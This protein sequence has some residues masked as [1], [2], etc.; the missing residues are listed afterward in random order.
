MCEFATSINK[1]VVRSQFGPQPQRMYEL[2]PK[3]HN[4]MNL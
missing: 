3:E 4:T 2:R 1:G